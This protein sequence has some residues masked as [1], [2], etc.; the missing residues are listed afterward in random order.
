MLFDEFES[1]M[2]RLKEISLFDR[3]SSDFRNNQKNINEFSTRYVFSRDAKFSNKIDFLYL[4][5]YNVIMVTNGSKMLVGNKIE[6]DDEN[7]D[8]RK[9]TSVLLKLSVNNFVIGF[10]DVIRLNPE[11]PS[12]MQGRECTNEDE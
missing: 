9:G 4:H 2:N 3:A 1:V 8:T 6:I 5:G 7:F 10:V 11:K 12:Y